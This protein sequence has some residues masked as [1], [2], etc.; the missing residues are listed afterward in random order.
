MLR[1]NIKTN[2]EKKLGQSAFKEN[3]ENT[4]EKF[5]Y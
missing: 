2:A 4:R 1:N 5:P 3:V